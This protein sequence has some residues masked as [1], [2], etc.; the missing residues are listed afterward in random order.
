MFRTLRE[1][2]GYTY[3]IAAGADARR[4]GGA[5]VVRGSVK[6]E[7]TGAAL[8]DLL[9]Q[10]AILREQPISAEE[11]AEARDGIVRG[12]PSRFATASGIAGQLSALSA[13][14]LPDDYWEGYARAVQEVSV[15]EVQRVAQRYL[16]PSRLTLVMVGPAAVVEPQLAALPLGTVEVE[17]AKNGLL[18]RKPRR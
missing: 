14:G 3:G 11:L 7:V 8:H 16:D 9:E 5:S 1:E 13:Y 15:A 18:P 10:L 12:L 6:A 17:R 4:L 2:K